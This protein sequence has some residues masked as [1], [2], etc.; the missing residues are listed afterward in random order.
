MDF[1]RDEPGP[2][3]KPLVVPSDVI[4]GVV[5]VSFPSVAYSEGVLT[6]L[7]RPEWEGLVAA[8]ETIN[9]LYTIWAPRGGV[10]KEWYFHAHTLDRYIVLSGSLRVGLFDGREDS[11]THSGFQTVDLYAA[12]E[13]GP[14]GLRIPPGVWHSL[15]WSSP[16][17]V[18]VNAKYPPFERAE[19]D[20]F[21]IP[22]DQLP[23]GIDWNV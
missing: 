3:H 19:P 21:R 17:G 22:L 10:R 5:V 2:I 20:K 15:N 16:A 23:E 12:G 18:L 11:P 7:F 6:E 9:H 1:I 8:G 14:S 4:A 13:G